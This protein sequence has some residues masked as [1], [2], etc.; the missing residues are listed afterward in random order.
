MPAFLVE[1]GTGLAAAT[2]YVSEAYADD[3]LGSSWAADTAAKEA[4][5][6]AATEYVDARWG[7]KFKSYPLVETQALEFPRTKLYNRY[8][9]EIEDPL[10]DDFLKAVTLYAQESANGTLYPNPS[11]TSAQQIKK[12][13]TVVGPITTE[14]EY[15]GIAN[16][17]SWLKFPLAD[18]LIKQYIYGIGGGAVRN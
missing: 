6:M 11:S 1:D 15:Q 7:T 14:K 8:G 5:L 9:V 4:A 3:Y 17:Y 12:T 13:K 18:K 2:S 10:P 16:D